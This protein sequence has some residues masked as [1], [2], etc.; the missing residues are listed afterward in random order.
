MRLVLPAAVIR[1]AE[2]GLDDEVG[3][4]LELSVVDTLGFDIVLCKTR[5]HILWNGMIG[6]K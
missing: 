4:R 5:K 2:D 1:S 6:T 3:L